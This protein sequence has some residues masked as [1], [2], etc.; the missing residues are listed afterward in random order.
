MNT[1]DE[2]I[3]KDSLLK[4]LEND[5]M[6]QKSLGRHRKFFKRLLETNKDN[7]DILDAM[8]DELKE[9]FVDGMIAGFTAREVAEEVWEKKYKKKHK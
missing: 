2:W 9:S 1:E 8:I 6:F 7:D 3:T 4:R 5:K